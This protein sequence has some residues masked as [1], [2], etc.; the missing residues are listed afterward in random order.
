MHNCV[1]TYVPG[2]KPVCICLYAFKLCKL[3]AHMPTCLHAYFETGR[4]WAKNDVC[5]AYMTLH[6]IC[7][8]PVCRHVGR[9]GCTLPSKCKAGR[10]PAPPLVANLNAQMNGDNIG[11][12]GWVITG[13]RLTVPNE[14]RVYSLYAPLSSCLERVVN[15]ASSRTAAQKRSDTRQKYSTALHAQDSPD[16]NNSFR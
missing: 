7:C 2:P 10:R 4:W 5:R 6:G 14:S 1:C 12:W 16:P 8:Q 15:L 13:K 3:Y 11:K 9:K